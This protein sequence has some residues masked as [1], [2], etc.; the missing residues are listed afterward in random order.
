MTN[1]KATKAELKGVYDDLK[2]LVQNCESAL[3]NAINH[4]T[5]ITSSQTSTRD[6]LEK[7]SFELRVT[8]EKWLS[9]LGKSPAEQAHKLNVNRSVNAAL[10]QAAG[11]IENLEKPEIMRNRL[12]FQ[13]QKVIREFTEHIGNKTELLRVVRNFSKRSAWHH[14]QAVEAWGG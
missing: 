14:G 8:Y 12:D 3:N 7:Q 13:F 11:R 4:L 5:A 6:Q 1:L 10:Q 2:H 9:A